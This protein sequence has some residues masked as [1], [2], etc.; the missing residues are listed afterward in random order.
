MATIKRISIDQCFLSEM[1][2]GHP[3][4][5]PLLATLR[6]S[7]AE[8]K[9]AC[10]I[11]LEESIF[12]SACLKP[13]LRQSIFDIQNELSGGFSFHSFAQQV[14]YGTFGLLMPEV[15]YPALRN[16]GLKIKP[17]TDFASLAQFHKQGKNDYADRL[18]KM[19]YPPA[20]YKKGMKGDDIMRHISMERAAS[21]YRLLG[22][23]K[24]SR[25]LNTGKDEWEVAVEVAASLL[26]MNIEVKDCEALI[27]KIL[28][29]QWE[30]IPHLWTHSR[31]NAQI[32]LGY[33]AGRKGTAND[34]LDVSRLAVALNDADV[35]L[36]DTAM[37]EIIK[38]S[39]MLEIFTEARVFS[40]Q[41]AQEAT[42]LVAAL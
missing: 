3:K 14:R 13:G 9:I 36:C 10:P 16:L 38:Q 23:I 17:G 35:V 40:M 27:K 20:S 42:D 15:V 2:K 25:S 6:K 41:Q 7:F 34:M 32:E 19:P 30:G 31:L 12:E 29:H 37:S 33:L 26:R 39:K 11:H 28:H 1:A 5:V 21:M 24:D 8:G 22:A 4:F 18:A